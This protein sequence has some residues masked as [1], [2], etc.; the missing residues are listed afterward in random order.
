[1]LCHNI[2]ISYNQY[3][4]SINISIHIQLYIFLYSIILYSNIYLSIFQYT[5]IYSLFCLLYL[6]YFPLYSIYI[7][8]Y[9][10][11]F[12]M[13]FML[14]GFLPIICGCFLHVHRRPWRAFLAAF[15]ICL[16]CIDFALKADS[17]PSFILA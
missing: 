13:D 8:L 7:Y 11:G 1:M 2:Y 3:I 17:W 12:C 16:H 14:V 6:F 15:A 9:S 4:L 10:Y 5:Y